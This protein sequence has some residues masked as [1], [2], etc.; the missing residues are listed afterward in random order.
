MKLSITRIE[1]NRSHLYVQSSIEYRLNWTLV[2]IKA[3]YLF[4]ASRHFKQTWDLYLK[5]LFE[6]KLSLT[7]FLSVK[8][9]K[10][11]IIVS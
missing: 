5:K 2:R 9:N 7:Y 1:R 6:G 11:N 3:N 8:M 10:R 4:N